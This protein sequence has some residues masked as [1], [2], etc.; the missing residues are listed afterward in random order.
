M[1]GFPGIAGQ[2]GTTLEAVDVG[3]PGWACQDDTLAFCARNQGVGFAIVGRRGYG[4]RRWLDKSSREKKIDGCDE[5][6]ESWP[7][8]S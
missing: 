2:V 5:T 1:L 4:R 8:P 6:E 7:F 3:V